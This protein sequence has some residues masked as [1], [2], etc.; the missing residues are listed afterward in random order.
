M[1]LLIALTCAMYSLCLLHDIQSAK[2]LTKE[3]GPVETLGAIMFL[4]SS[5]AFGL[6]YLRSSSSQND[7]MGQIRLAK[8]NIF[9]LLLSFLFLLGF[10]EEISWGQRIFDIETPTAIAEVNRQQEINIHN[11]K[12]FHGHSENRKSLLRS[13]PNRSFSI[14]WFVYCVCIPLAAKFSQRARTIFAK[15][16]LPVIPLQYAFLFSFTHVASLAIDAVYP[17]RL[18]SIVETK[19]TV[20]AI[21][22]ACVALGQVVR[23]SK[24]SHVRCASP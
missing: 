6:A 7:H 24:G 8:K 16:R 14:F 15:I 20:I 22:F 4:I 23:M 17:M 19:E 12:W 13:I 5:V 18:H 9:Y 21:L 3:D 1:V 10:L 2:W 11:L